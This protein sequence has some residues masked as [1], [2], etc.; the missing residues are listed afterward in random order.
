MSLPD[1]A[2]AHGEVRC[3]ALIRSSNE[4]FVVDEVLGFEPSG[5][6]EHDYLQVEKTGANTDWVARQLARHAGVPVRHVG[7]SGLKDRHAVTRQW[8]SVPRH[9]EPDWLKFRTDGVRLLDVHRHTRKLRRGT[10]RSNCFRIVLREGAWDGIDDR[11]RRIA[12]V[13]VPNYF[14]EQRFGRAGG[15]LQLA[16][17]WAAGKRL[18]PA[19]RSLA[20]SSA[21]SLLFNESLDRRV[22]DETWN[23]VLAGDVVNLD[24]SASVF[25]VA[26]PDEELLRRCRAF[27]VHPAGV[28]WGEDAAGDVP[29]RWQA[30]FDRDRVKV[31]Y[32]SL[33]LPVRGLVWACV[34]DVLTLEFVLG[35]G[36]YATAVLREIAA[37]GDARRS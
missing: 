37:V 23:T 16:D 5:D 25:T 19:K 35:R 24:G 34:D 12:A 17:D 30:A 26:A 4:D 7:Y 32:R 31:G 8:F 28:L 11:L 15:N 33:R 14:G 1:W 10:H 36:A 6:G 27:D 20:I 13:G 2:R 29:A 21:R 9:H 3:E 22:R 18:P